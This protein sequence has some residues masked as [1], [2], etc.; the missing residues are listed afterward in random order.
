M[1]C[2][3]AAAF[4]RTS[5]KSGLPAASAGSLR[6][7]RNF[8]SAPCVLAPATPSIGVGLVAGDGQQP[9]DAGK[10]RLRVVVVGFLRQIDRRPLRRIGRLRRGEAR[11][12][13][14][15]AAARIGDLEVAVADAQFGVARL[16]H[17]RAAVDGR[18]ARMHIDHVGVERA[19]HHLAA[20][21][22]IDAEPAAGRDI[23]ALFQP[24]RGFDAIAGAVA[25]S[26][27]GVRRAC[28]QRHECCAGRCKDA[29]RTA[30]HGGDA[31]T[32]I[33]VRP[34]QSGARHLG[35]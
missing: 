3:L 17:G 2:G 29:V 13:G 15:R 27:F 16:R 25:Q 23:G 35:P 28:R 22:G 33:S 20:G 30:N 31:R 1:P 24:D 4:S 5:K 11:L 32:R 7:F 34:R 14:D 26:E 8:V 10:P 6:S 19:V 18:R 21:A 12:L 9:L